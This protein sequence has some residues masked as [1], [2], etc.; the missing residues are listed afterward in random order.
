[1]NNNYQTIQVNVGLNWT[2]GTDS[3]KF[4]Q[5]LGRF[6]VETKFPHTGIISEPYVSTWTD[7]SGATYEDSCIAFKIT[8]PRLHAMPIGEIERRIETIRVILKQDAIA[9]T[10]RIGTAGSGCEH[11]DVYYG[12]NRPDDALTFDPSYFHY[13]K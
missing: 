5:E 11:S 12:P 13:V 8:V 9:F 6:L 3:G 7:S 1:M 10:T 2:D 4:D